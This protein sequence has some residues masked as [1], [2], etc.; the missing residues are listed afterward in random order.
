MMHPFVNLFHF[1]LLNS[2]K[3]DQL[4]AKTEEFFFIDLYLSISLVFLIKLNRLFSITESLLSTA[5]ICNL[6]PEISFFYRM[7]EKIDYLL[8]IINS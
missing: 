8:T 7:F 2:L 5:Q 4:K 3:I 1:L 6:S